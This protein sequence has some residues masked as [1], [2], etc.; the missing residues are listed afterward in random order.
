MHASPASK[1]TERF[2]Y[3]RCRRRGIFPMLSQSRGLFDPIVIVF[4]KG[5]PARVLNVMADGSMVQSAGSY[6]TSDETVTLSDEHKDAIYERWFWSEMKSAA[7]ARR[8]GL[9]EHAHEHLRL[10]RR[11]RRY[12]EEARNPQPIPYLEAAE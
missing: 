2:I 6:T 12:G 3:R 8:F 10:A 1:V 5:G 11:F 7:R 9:Y 4:W